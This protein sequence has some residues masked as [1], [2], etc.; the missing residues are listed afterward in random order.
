MLRRSLFSVVNRRNALSLSQ[1]SVYRSAL[2]NADK[3]AVI[4]STGR[5]SYSNLLSASVQLREKLL[6]SSN[7]QQK[8]ANKR[9]AFLCNPDASFV[10]AQWT[11][12]LS[13]AVCIP[14]CKD[15]PQALLDY[16]IDDAKCSHLIVSPEYEKL[17]RPLADKFKIPLISITDKD[18]QSGKTKNVLQSSNLQQY[19][20]FSKSS[21]D[22]L[23]LYT[24]GTTG[25]PK[26][27]VHT[28]ATLRAQMDA[29]LSAWRLTK[30]DTVLN[31]LPLHHVHG[32]IN[33]V[34]SPLYAGGT[35]V[36]MNKFD[37]EQTWNHLLND[38]NPPI[39]VFSAVPTIY[40][41]LIEHITK[42]SKSKDV[43]KLC[44]D[45]IR[46]FLSGSA[47]L[48]ESTF[49]KWR[50]LTGFEIVEQFGSSETGRVLSNKLE[51]KKL[52]GRVGLPMPD[53]TVRLVQKDEQDNDNIVAEGTYDKMTILQ[54]DH[55]GTAQGE[56]YAKG[57]TIFKHYFN[58][59]EATRKAF[60]SQ[61]FFMMG[62]MAEYDQA[63][64]TFRILG[65]SSVDIIKSGGYKISA[66]DVETVILHHPLVSECVV[67]GVKDLEW[68]ERVTAVVVLQPGKKEQDLTLEDLRNYCKKKLPGYQCPTQL[69]IVD[70]LERNAVGKVNKKE[71]NA[72]LFPPTSKDK[73]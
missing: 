32:M 38:R 39:N 60:D 31:V 62:D 6:S 51:G 64:N 50:E 36:M 69:K 52:A 2:D 68:G 59:E 1:R 45:H 54:K 10:V 16:Y 22:A 33:C 34:M 66:L 7:A 56:I 55:N 57:P 24:S 67:I 37:P 73:K 23:I 44:S 35:V 70:K 30:E 5:Y 42:S 58:K 61:G 25:K 19:D 28:I 40:I 53:L 3:T 14:L 47:A 46:L 18:L 43:K 15:H 11:C 41:K 63:N 8:S 17:L 20:I 65:R 12:W 27:V 29:M 4:D 71:L 48:P 26:G 72:K 49:Q 21:D 13:R 9:I